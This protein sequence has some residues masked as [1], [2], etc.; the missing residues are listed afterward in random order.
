MRCIYCDFQNLNAE[1]DICY[2]PNCHKT[3]AKSKAVKYGTLV[4]KSV[5]SF[6]EAF[7][8][9][10]KN[11][12]RRQV[13]NASKQILKLIPNDTLAFVYYE[14]LRKD[15]YSDKY[16][17]Y[18]NQILIVSTKE[19]V[20]DVI[21]III[22]NVYFCERKPI[23]NIINKMELDKTYIDKLNTKIYELGVKTPMDDLY[24]TCFSLKKSECDEI[25]RLSGYIFSAGYLCYNGNDIH[26]D[27]INKNQDVTH[28]LNNSEKPIDY[29]EDIDKRVNI[30]IN[31][32]L[33]GIET[34]DKLPFQLIDNNI[35]TF[36]MYPQTIKEPYVK[37]TKINNGY[38]GS[39]GAKY[40]KRKCILSDYKYA[41]R[42]SDG[43]ECTNK[44]EYFRLEPLKWR[45]IEYNEDAI[46][47]LAQ[48]IIDTEIYSLG[49]KDNYLNSTLYHFL[50]E[51]FLNFAFT[52]AQKSII[53][54]NIKLLGN[55]EFEIIKEKY[56][57]NNIKSILDKKMTDYSKA[58]EINYYTKDYWVD[59][60]RN[61][62]LFQ[63]LVRLSG[64]NQ[65]MRGV[66]PML[67][68]NINYKEKK[69]KQT[70]KKEYMYFGLYPQSLK[71]E[72]VTILD[73]KDEKGYF[74]GS[75]GNLYAKQVGAPYED[76]LKFANGKII[77]PGKEYYFKVEPIKWTILDS[78][79]D[80]I[81]LACDEIIDINTFDLKTNN[82]ETSS[83][84]KYL[85]NEFIDNAF[86][87]EEKGKIKDTLINVDSSTFDEFS[88]LTVNSKCQDKVFLLS[89]EDIRNVNYGFDESERFSL[90]RQ[91]KGTDYALAKGM[92][93]FD[94]KGWYYLRTSI[95]DEKTGVNYVYFDGTIGVIDV[96]FKDGGIIPAIHIK[97]TKNGNI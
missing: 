73:D 75:D 52:G 94:D 91:K 93:Q 12:D 4:N 40:A 65:D 77:E 5:K 19:E 59:C 7:N 17:D 84:R 92:C 10:I 86:T 51:Y 39:D 69:M 35:V 90:T 63:G 56:G 44:E 46:C 23:L 60:G 81:F 18:L 54:G 48:D 32:F 20:M 96:Y 15:R 55:K 30:K 42:F 78:K 1:N 87:F 66:V 26:D 13:I 58:K 41:T 11:H 21:D 34:C 16:T 79:D 83:I 89:L 22:D 61:N 85:N 67:W 57:I 70:S 27:N 62:I 45:I 53:K 68:I 72:D 3:M 9:G 37:I 31:D 47:L 33:K 25:E 76:E 97:D 29:K 80:D 6:R 64:I 28:I 71:N 49:V 82:Y 36:G 2:C 8:E 88:N 24:P 43:S 74:K 14:A 50:N 38:I 95:I